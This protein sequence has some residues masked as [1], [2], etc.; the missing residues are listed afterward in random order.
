MSDWLK[1]FDKLK[2]V[3]R[4]TNGEPIR[5]DTNVEN[6]PGLGAPSADDSA[7]WLQQWDQEKPQFI[8][9]QGEPVMTD[10]A[11]ANVLDLD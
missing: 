7:L 4:D 9:H 2:P 11:L 8:D 6:V 5:L 3:F 1:R 10:T